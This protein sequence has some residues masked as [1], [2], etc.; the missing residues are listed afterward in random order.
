MKYYFIYLW[1][2]LVV[3]TKCFAVRQ[4]L[5]YRK[6]KRMKAIG[7]ILAMQRAHILGVNINLLKF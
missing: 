2:H 7:L 4:Y 5:Q 1:R 6:L 3:D